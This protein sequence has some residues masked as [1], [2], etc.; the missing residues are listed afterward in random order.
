MPRPALA[1]A[2]AIAMEYCAAHDIEYTET[3][4]IQAWAIVVTYMN[5][6]GLAAAG[7]AFSCP[8]ASSLGR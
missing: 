1:Q 8:A 4:I 5:T 7:N 6:V 2:R 3:N